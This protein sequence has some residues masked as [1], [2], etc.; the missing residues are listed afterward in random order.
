MIVLTLLAPHP[1]SWG[2]INWNYSG[3]GILVGVPIE[4]WDRTD[5]VGCSLC[6][7]CMHFSVFLLTC[8][9]LL[10]VGYYST[11]VFGY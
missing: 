8:C 5:F 4:N 1:R 10:R 6:R 11:M 7:P 3:A 2:Q 9:R